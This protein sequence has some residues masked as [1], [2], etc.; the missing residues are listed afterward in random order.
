VALVSE[1]RSVAALASQLRAAAVS[2][3]PK[4]LRA[5]LVFEPPEAAPAA[6]LLEGGSRRSARAWVFLAPVAEFQPQVAA[7]RPG[8]Y[9]ELL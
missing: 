2:R 8:Y 9:K 6:A 3:E 5:V 1:R 4:V 7:R